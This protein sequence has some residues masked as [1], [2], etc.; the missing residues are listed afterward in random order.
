[1]I[2]TTTDMASSSSS[3]PVLK[4]ACNCRSSQMQELFGGCYNGRQWVTGTGT[5]KMWY[6]YRYTQKY[7]QVTHADPY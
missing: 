5:G 2:R 6:G 4:G 3:A 1:M 7:L